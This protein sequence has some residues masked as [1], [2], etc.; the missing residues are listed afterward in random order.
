[1]D[2][3]FTLKFIEQ[4]EE[5]LVNLQNDKNRNEQRNMNGHR[6]KPIIKTDILWSTR[7]T[8]MWT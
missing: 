5:L 4:E 8:L 1:M 2:T 3:Y 6:L 7:Y